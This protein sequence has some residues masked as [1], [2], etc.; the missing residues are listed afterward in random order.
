MARSRL[1]GRG[2]F[3]SEHFWDEGWEYVGDA[4]NF[5]VRLFYGVNEVKVV[6]VRKANL[7][8]GP[9]F[10]VTSLDLPDARIDRVFAEELKV[11]EGVSLVDCYSLRRFGWAHEK[12]RWRRLTDLER[13]GV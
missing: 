8:E 5:G 7:G 10:A 2:A 4:D 9:I 11:P 6:A 3:G 13:L 1:D 12:N